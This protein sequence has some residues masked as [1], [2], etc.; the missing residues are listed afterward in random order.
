MERA[1]SIAALGSRLRWPCRRGHHILRC[2]FSSVSVPHMDEAA[3]QT[4]S[5]HVGMISYVVTKV[6]VSLCAGTAIVTI[7]IPA[8]S[9]SQSQQF[10]TRPPGPALWPLQCSPPRRATSAAPSLWRFIH[11]FCSDSLQG[12]RGRALELFPDCHG[13]SCWITSGHAELVPGPEELM[14]SLMPSLR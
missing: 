9:N 10:S 11:S 6:L 14:L 5:S 8:E 1:S 7:C 4:I 3:R 2:G 13:L 12:A